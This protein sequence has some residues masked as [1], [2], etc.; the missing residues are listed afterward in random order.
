MGTDPAQA[1]SLLAAGNARE[2]RG[3]LEGALRDYR[4][5]VAAAPA[6]PRAH[7]NVGNALMAMRD[8]DAAAA[9]FG[10]ALALDPGFAP[11]RFNLG[12]LHRKRGEAAAAEASFRAALAGDPDMTDASVALANVLDAEGR[13]EEAEAVL[14]AALARNPRHSGAAHNLGLLL[15]D[16]RQWDEAEAA[17]E[18]ALAADPG[19]AGALG[20][21]ANSRAQTGWLRD[22]D[23]LY[24]RAIAADPARDEAYSGLLFALNLRDDLDAATIFAEHVRYG[25]HFGS[26]TAA[27]PVP[28]RPVAPGGR[29]RVG[30]VS[31][32]FKEHPVALF[33][34]PVLAHHDRAGFEIF[35]YSNSRK[36]DRI[37][38]E[39]RSLADRW[40][41]IADLDDDAARQLI[42]DDG[43]D[44]L[45]DLSGHTGL[46]RL[47]LFGRRSAPVQASWLG[48]LNTTGVPAMDFRI[49][50]R[51]TDPPGTTER[52]HTERLVRMP[53]SQWCY[54][55]VYDIPVVP[56]PPR[57]DPPRIVFGSFN[58]YPKLSDACL[59]LWCEVLRRLPAARLHVLDVR[60][61]RT[62]A[63]FSGRMQARG[64]DASRITLLP[65]LAIG[66]Y[67]AA[68]S[69]VDIALDTIPYNGGTT[70][71][72]ILWM[73]V[74][75]VALEGGRGISRSGASILRTLGMP[76]LVARNRDQY[77][78]LT[79]ALANDPARRAE[80]R[81]TLRPRLAASPLM[82]VAEF[83]RDLEAVFR[84]MLA[85]RSTA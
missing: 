69:A 52:L 23:A 14:R 27:A 38:R 13:G 2:D 84:A 80:L 30:Y 12:N 68:I 48:Y 50:D 7:L 29:I 44:V 26:T 33:L 66:D 40:R 60:T 51:H 77:L 59:D 61:E 34:R 25:P 10:Q 9:A 32:D 19:F 75:L 35:C 64:V 28:P 15:N 74:P 72:D 42:I 85:S 5:A 73:G 46:S 81:R 24:R 58:Q 37:T 16:R 4:A 79:Q 62:A 78:A 11:A 41:V 20:A 43:I 70:T 6:L 82:A 76:E 22:A 71:L 54:Q 56:V 36:E 47:A 57:Q 83:T 8:F 65:R 3:D 53:H 63:A 18:Q 31:G 21:L 45:V 1:L 55:P 17:F 67:F 39:I 49:C